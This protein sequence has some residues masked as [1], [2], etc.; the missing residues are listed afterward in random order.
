MK[1]KNQMALIKCHECGAEVSTEAKRCPKCGA[2]TK[3]RWTAFQIVVGGFFSLIVL[4]M[5]I[6]GGHKEVQSASNN[7]ELPVQVISAPP[8]QKTF[9]LARTGKIDEYQAAKNQ[10]IQSAIFNSVD[11]EMNAIISKQGRHLVN[12]EGT[13]KT[14]YTSHAGADVYIKIVSANNVEYSLQNEAKAGTS[15]YRQIAELQEGQ[16]VTFSGKLERVGSS[17]KWECSLTELGSLT[18]PE[19]KV[20]F[21][22][23]RPFNDTALP[24][25][26]K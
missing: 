23:I 22:S 11:A 7:T 12:W 6:G 10:V 19:F 26:A 1:G 13:V 8:I 5:V 4:L 2:R 16:R 9:E 25:M 24:S 3:K 14:I 18:N 20:S 17:S 21:E 15:I